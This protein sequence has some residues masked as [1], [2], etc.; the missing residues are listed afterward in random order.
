MNSDSAQ[1]IDWDQFFFHRSVEH[2]DLG[3]HAIDLVKKL[4]TYEVQ[5]RL[6]TNQVLQH[7]FLTS[8]VDQELEQAAMST[9]YALI[10][11]SVINGAGD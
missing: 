3:T 7:P 2:G 9:L 10:E 4:I 8:D 1:L 6:T 11:E 5:D